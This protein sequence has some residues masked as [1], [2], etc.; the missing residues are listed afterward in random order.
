MNI[1]RDSGVIPQRAEAANNSAYADWPFAKIV[2]LSH[3][4]HPHQT[5]CIDLEYPAKT[6][7]EVGA[8]AVEKRADYNAKSSP[9]FGA[10]M[11]PSTRA[12]RGMD[13]H[14]LHHHAKNSDIYS[15][16]CAH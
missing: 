3:F 9:Q 11:A 13:L 4:A 12:H 5:T 8:S 6:T 14:L 1:E 16:V 7:H 10:R 2:R 15:N